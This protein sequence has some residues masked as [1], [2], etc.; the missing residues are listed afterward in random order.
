MYFS[1]VDEDGWDGLWWIPTDGGDPT[2]VVA[3]DDP[4]VAVVSRSLSVGPEHFYFTLGENESDIRV[5]DLEW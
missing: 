5:V 1:A 4:S 2:K 3:F